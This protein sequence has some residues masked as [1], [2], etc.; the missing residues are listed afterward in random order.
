MISKLHAFPRW[1]RVLILLVVG[2]T[3]AAFGFLPIVA[4]LLKYSSSMP[5]AA[6]PPD[7]WLLISI[8]TIGWLVFILTYQLFRTAGGI[9]AVGKSF[10]DDNR[11]QAILILNAIMF[12]AGAVDGIVNDRFR[13]T[14]L[15]IVIA[16]L[17]LIGLGLLRRHNPQ[18]RNIHT[19]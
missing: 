8:E 1:L 9:Y 12:A 5:I 13:G 6:I 3:I 18:S 16:D 11:G 14:S 19:T 15:A 10:L 2:L 7:Y 17:G 4:I